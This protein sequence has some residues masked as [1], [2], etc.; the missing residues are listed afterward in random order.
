MLQG[1]PGDGMANNIN[2]MPDL[3][4]TDGDSD[5]DAEEDNYP[6]DFGRMTVA[7]RGGGSGTSSGSA[8]AT[9]SDVAVINDMSGV[10]NH[11][12]RGS[13]SNHQVP[14][15]ISQNLN[16]QNSN[17]ESPSGADVE[18]DG[19]AGDQS[20]SSG[21]EVTVIN[22][23]SPASSSTEF[24]MATTSMASTISGS[25]LNQQSGSGTTN[26]SL[27]E[28]YEADARSA[29]E[30]GDTT[31]H[32]PQ[33]TSNQ[34]SSGT[35]TPTEVVRNSSSTATLTSQQQQQQ[36]QRQLSATSSGEGALHLPV[37][38]SMAGMGYNSI[39]PP[40]VSETNTPPPSAYTTNNGRPPRPESRSNVEDSFV[41]I[42]ED[43]QTQSDSTGSSSNST[44]NSHSIL[45]GNVSNR[46]NPHEQLSIRRWNEQC[47]R[48]EL[49]QREDTLTYSNS[50]SNL[51]IS[52][53]RLSNLWWR[54]KKTGYLAVFD[55]APTISM[56]EEAPSGSR[57]PGRNSG[58][59]DADIKVLITTGKIIG[60]LP[61]GTTIM[62]S[63]MITIDDELLQAQSLPVQP[64]D[65]NIDEH[66]T[67]H[68]AYSGSTYKFLEIISPI[69]GYILFG[70]DGYSFAAPGLPSNYTEPE[71]WTWRV[72]CPDGAFV[73]Q[74]LELTSVHVDTIPFGSF[75]KVT[76]KTVNS[77]G[78][79]RLHVEA[80]V[81][82]NDSD[83]EDNTPSGSNE[84][85]S[86][87][88]I[89]CIKGWVSEEL[90]PLSGQSG[91]VVQPVPFPVPA[92]YRVTLADGAVIR[93]D[94]EL[95]S[96]QIGL[97][98]MGSLLTVIGRAY[99][100]HPMDQCI[101]RLQLAGGGGWISCR[102]NRR[103]P[104]DELVVEMV[105]V[106]GSFD[107]YDPGLYH[108]EKQ[109]QVLQEYN[110]SL[111]SSVDNQNRT[112]PQ[113][114]RTG[115]GDLSSINDEE[116]E[117]DGQVGSGERAS[118]TLDTS[119]ELSGAISSLTSS[120]TT[121]VPA[122]YRSG[123]A[124]HSGSGASV[125]SHSSGKGCGSKALADEKCLIC[126]TENRS[127]TIVHGETGHVACCLKCARI[128]K[129]RGDRCP[130]CRLP[131]DSVIQQFWA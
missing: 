54:R 131:I 63:R 86:Q 46:L 56:K 65:N 91:P 113:P 61:P 2:T 53:R 37:P 23:I 97:A 44:S 122:L 85:P 80:T 10:P 75:V 101:E 90:N 94:V 35:T 39:L 21:E 76:G 58:N 73:R 66:T 104:M 33:S 15:E 62:A 95:S 83:D 22:S 77:M 42:H 68:E 9:N 29:T 109:R 26:L 114:Q 16:A 50:T 52:Q 102:L 124:A 89:K 59:N 116:E 110:R 5:H 4:S 70:I 74:G 40:I 127:A 64:N 28:I 103:P 118:G 12:Q 25:N 31:T 49:Q 7:S 3:T 105:G 98:P 100:E 20:S 108:I 130:V 120:A 60:Q 71:M 34:T 112:Q 8:S 57:S 81:I 107:P 82:E 72:T 69:N 99:S 18:S 84:S 129:A 6:P 43:S 96:S 78:L 1:I 45:T 32:P 24:V 106:D 111:S 11:Q 92:V 87:S 117:E 93:S 48:R 19:N 55:S 126:L 17:S 27:S 119:G 115:T 125:G 88:N 41:M 79:S 38:L 51:N 123:V 121:A 13:T 30:T 47:R 128:L 67:T 36:Q 14:S